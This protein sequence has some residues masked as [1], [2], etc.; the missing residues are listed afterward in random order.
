MAL[1]NNAGSLLVYCTVLYLLSTNSFAC[2]FGRIYCTVLLIATTLTLHP[3][4]S[5]RLIARQRDDGQDTSFYLRYCTLWMIGSIIKAIKAVTVKSNSLS[6]SGNIVRTAT[7]ST[8]AIGIIILYLL[9]PMLMLLSPH[10]FY[11]YIVS[12]CSLIN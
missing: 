1:F 10:G 8:L 5:N 6:C 7:D 11:R 4:T 3:V 2:L 9:L 12:T